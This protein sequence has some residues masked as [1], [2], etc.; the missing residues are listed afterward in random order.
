MDY[1]TRSYVERVES[2]EKLKA[3]LLPLV[4]DDILAKSFV[5][6]VESEIAQYG[7]KLSRLQS[8]SLDALKCIQCSRFEDK[9]NCKTIRLGVHICALC[10]RTISEMLV[11]SEFEEKYEIPE[12]TIKQHATSPADPLSAFKEAGMLRKSG[13]N[14]LIH[15]L[16]WDLF[17]AEKYSH[18]AKL[19]K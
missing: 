6:Q 5:S 19:P 18:K 11:A 12:G 4:G 7:I 1:I 14:W 16:L 13:R 17:Y 3:D 8:K 10:M 15:R 9:N 2:L